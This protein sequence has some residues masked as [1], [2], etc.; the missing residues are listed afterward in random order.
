MERQAGHGE[1]IVD[2]RRPRTPPPPVCVFVYCKLRA[3][4]Y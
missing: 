3:L 2:R 4:V 1:Q